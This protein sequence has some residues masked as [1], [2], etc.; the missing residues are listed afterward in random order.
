MGVA[1]GGYA[2]S[3]HGSLSTR[4]PVSKYFSKEHALYPGVDNMG[5][6]SYRPLAQPPRPL[7]VRGPIQDDPKYSY[8]MRV[9]DPEKRLRYFVHLCQVCGGARR[10]PQGPMQELGTCECLVMSAP[11][12]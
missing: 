12:T 10:R 8:G 4:L 7:P 5:V 9:S 6:I 1:T 2:H 11:A 3:V